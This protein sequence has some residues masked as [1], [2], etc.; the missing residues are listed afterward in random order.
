[1]G[2]Y[3]PK[4]HGSCNFIRTMRVDFSK[5]GSNSSVINEKIRQSVHTTTLQLVRHTS[6]LFRCAHT[7]WESGMG[8]CLNINTSFMV[9]TSDAGIASL[10]LNPGQ[11]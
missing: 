8:G 11:I 5:V 3:T 2:S 7:A 9:A 10:R 4:Q 1:M 6:E